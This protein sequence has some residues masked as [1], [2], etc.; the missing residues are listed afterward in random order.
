MTLSDAVDV[1][2]PWLRY[3]LHSFSFPNDGII[4]RPG[5]IYGNRDVGPMTLPLGIVM[6]PLEMVSRCLNVV[7]GMYRI[8]FPPVRRWMMQVTCRS[9]LNAFVHGGIRTIVLLLVMRAE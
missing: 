8:I 5:G 4:L 9:P 7:N 3:W 2:T 6:R 1:A